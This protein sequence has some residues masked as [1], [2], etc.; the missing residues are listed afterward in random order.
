LGIDTGGTYTDAVLLDDK[1]GVIGKAKALTTK[2]DLSVGIQSA[3]EAVMPDP[4]PDIRAVSLSTTLATNA[5][6]E[7]QGSP[8]CL[9]L[10]GYDPDLLSGMG[11]EKIVANGAIVFIPGGHTS[12][13]EEQAPL[14]IDAAR[15]AILAHAQHV[16][17]F[18]ISGFFGVRNPKHELQV[19]QLVRDLTGLPVTC[20]HELTTHL[21]A[22]RRA[23]TV[24]LNS[25]LIP[26]LQQ[27][28]LAVRD[29]LAR[30]GIYAPLMIV[31]GDGSLIDAK[32][33]LERPV[34]T[35]LSGPAASVVGARYLADVDD[36]FVI[37]MGGTTT[38]IA[39]LRNGQPFLNLNGAWVGDWQTMVEAIDIHTTGL[40]GDSEV[41]QNEDG[42]LCVGPRRVT[43]LSQLSVQYRETLDVLRRQAQDHV[44]KGAA[45]KDAGRFIMR[46][47]PLG[48]EQGNLTSTQQEIWGILGDGPVPLSQILGRVKY[49]PLYR[50]SLEELIERGLVAASAFTPT[51]AVHVLG[52]YRCG[53]LE[54]AE[55]GAGLWATQLGVSVEQFCEM[56]VRRVVVEL[57]RAV[58][59]SALAEEGGLILSSQD[60]VGRLFIEQALASDDTGSFSVA[61]ALRCPLVAIGAPVATYLPSVA[62]QLHAKLCIPEHAEVANAIGAV[63]GEVVQTVCILIRPLNGAEAYRVHL[64]F[65]VRDF[66]RLEDA[67]ACAQDVSRQLAQDRARHAGA[68]LVDVHIDRHDRTV[69]GGGGWPDEIYLETEVIA[70]AVGRMPLGV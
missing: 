36:V 57:G 54:A 51:D 16:A 40:G 1:R 2:Y 29:T 50:R 5:I 47:R 60:Y 68:S 59:A 10:I 32:M 48:I 27:L 22:P 37:D 4:P 58:I 38:D 62:S 44:D 46:Q 26:L 65:E 34:E 53:S 12:T 63:V 35:I 31:K 3:V 21:N 23:F 7:G 6:V 28:I 66:P 55:L 41:W 13:G 67:V 43:P 18:A 25:R 64:P 19:R 69:H 14:D 24:A 70:T 49:P 9:L 56:V 30:Q 42:G 11:F 61:L 8:I 45:D 20:G 52:Q 15:Q 17:A 39:A 33:A